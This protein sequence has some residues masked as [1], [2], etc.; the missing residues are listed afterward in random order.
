MSQILFLRAALLVLLV[1]YITLTMR[2]ALWKAEPRAPASQLH[3]GRTPAVIGALEE[4]SFAAL[5]P[6]SNRSGS[7]MNVD[8]YEYT[9]FEALIDGL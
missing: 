2:K 8:A 1:Y 9:E 7:H 5:L 4:A 3:R 6:T